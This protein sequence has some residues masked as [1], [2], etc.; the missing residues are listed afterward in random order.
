MISE[1][2]GVVGERLDELRSNRSTSCL[3]CIN[4]CGISLPPSSA[5]VAVDIAESETASQKI[6]DAV[7]ALEFKLGTILDTLR[8]WVDDDEV[9]LIVTARRGAD[10]RERAESRSPPLQLCSANV[11][12]PLI[13]RCS[14]GERCGRR[15]ALTQ[16]VDLAPTLL[17]WLAVESAETSLRGLSLIPLLRGQTTRTRE[18]AYLSGTNGEQAVRTNDFYLIEAA[19]DHRGSATRWLFKKPEDRWDI[20]DVADQFPEVADSMQASR[21]AADRE[22]GKQ[23][24]IRNWS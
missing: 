14:S 8:P 23:T 2:A 19:T 17:D 1:N 12:L 16:S 18:V 5:T 6:A 20:L 15:R 21:P 13:V 7:R 10:L 24:E 3:I 22:D 9:L 11:H 4:V